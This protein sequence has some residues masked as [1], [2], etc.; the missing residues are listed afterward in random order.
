MKGNK[1]DGIALADKIKKGMLKKFLKD[2]SEIKKS[3]S[4]LA[5]Q[6]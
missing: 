2:V 5:K 1:I 4:H 3:R 6:S